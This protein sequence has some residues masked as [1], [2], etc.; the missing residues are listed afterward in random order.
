MANKVTIKGLVFKY[1]CTRKFK[2]N[3]V[4]LN[5]K[6]YTKYSKYRSVNENLVLEYVNEK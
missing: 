5:L 1:F 6:L 2:V 4:S 3:L